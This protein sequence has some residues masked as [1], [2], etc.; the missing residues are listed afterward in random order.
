[1]EEKV[2]LLLIL[3]FDNSNNLIEERYI[4]KPKTFNDLQMMIKYCFTK[5]PT[6]YQI[7]YTNEFN[8]KIVIN[9]DEEYKQSKDILFI[10][11]IKQDDNKKES[12]FESDYNKLSESKQEILD[13][14]YNCSICDENIKTEKPLLCYRC[15]KLF[16]KK[17]L[18][19]W[20][21][22][23]NEQNIKYSCPKCKF[24][25]PLNDWQEKLNYV[26][27]RLSEVNMM[28]E[29]T[30]KNQLNNEIKS[31]YSIFK[32]NT[33]NTFE[34]IL[35]KIDKINALLEKSKPIIEKSINDFN[36]I[37]Q[38]EMPFKIV[39]GLNYDRRIY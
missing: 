16:H 3:L 13:E 39:G 12:M 26:D 34:N 31:E 33:Y 8:F 2:D 27:E 38:Y 37:N 23:C 6:D 24:E 20:N 21:D 22:K 17:C 11:E 32:L 1:M 4:P 25:L 30:N 19:N 7:F 18:H 28:K 9:N 35:N 14:K 29:L 10:N 36:N 15:Q 5:L